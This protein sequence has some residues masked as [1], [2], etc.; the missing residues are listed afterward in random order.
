MAGGFSVEPDSLRVAASQV[1]L[2]ARALEAASSRLQGRLAALGDVCGGDQA[3][4][5]FAAGYLP[6]AELLERAL[7]EMVGGLEDI[8]SGLRLMA[9]SYEGSDAA[10]V[11]RGGPG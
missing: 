5:A 7:R 3:G 8:D 6:R 1:E 2:E 9:A 11:L 4:R 10:N